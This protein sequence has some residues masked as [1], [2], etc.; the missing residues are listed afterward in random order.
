MSLTL[1]RWITSRGVDD[2]YICSM[3]RV[4][5]GLLKGAVI[6][7]ALGWVAFKVGVTGGVAAFLTYAVIGGVVGM[8]CGKP[9]WRQDTLWTSALKGLFGVGVG[10]GLWLLG[11]KLLGG[12]HIALPAALGAPP[13][14]T[15]A[16]LPILLGPLVGAIWGTFV[17]VDDGG[18]AKAAADKSKS[19]PAA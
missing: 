13:E 14:R 11:R 9:P 8:I 15:F 4:V 2:C 17:E 6:G 3:L 19:K 1:W 12:V 5:F 16:E 18:G 10:I 7:G